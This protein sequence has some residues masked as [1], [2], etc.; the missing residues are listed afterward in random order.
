ME[1][2][3]Y[4]VELKKIGNDDCLLF[5]ID[6]EEYLINLNSEDQTNLKDLFY[7][8]INLTFEEHPIFKLSDQSQNYPTKIFVEIGNEYLKDL[9]IEIEKIL[10]IQP[11]F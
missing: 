10:Q 4:D 6:G 3:T 5:I 8:I 9:N 2:K 11:K 1:K 7:K